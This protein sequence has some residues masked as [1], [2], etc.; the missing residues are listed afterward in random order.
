MPWDS[1]LKKNLLKKNTCGFHEQCMGPTYL[2][3][4]RKHG[5]FHCNANS[6]YKFMISRVFSYVYC[7]NNLHHV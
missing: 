4:N 1:I 5:G 7:F 6:H 3:H 2:K